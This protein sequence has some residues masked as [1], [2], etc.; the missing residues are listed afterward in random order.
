M[1]RVA[2]GAGACL[3]PGG[4]FAH[5][6]GGPAVDPWVWV[7]ML[8]ALGLW[9]AGLIRSRHRPPPRRTLSFGAGWLVLAAALAGPL[10]RA[11]GESLAAH[12]LQHMLLLA[13]APPLLLLGRPLPTM[14][15]GLPRP[16]QRRT[17]PGLA[18]LYRDAA[19]PGLLAFLV[20]GAVIWLWHLPGPYQAAVQNLMLHHLEHLLFLVTALWFWWTLVMPAR[21]GQGRFGVAALWAALTMMHTGFLGAL[22]TFAPRPLYP[23]HPGGFAGFGV[24]EDQQLAGLLMWVPGS[25]AY[26]TAALILCR[27][28]MRSWPED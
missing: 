25:V 22:L 6:P 13:V 8:L 9:S 10:E 19:A 18:W 28:W 2:F 20:H 21:H 11:A 15:R 23:G 27:L 3:L 14:Q 16:L 7:P 26:A 17:G 24:L 12:M 1:T 4:A 5:A